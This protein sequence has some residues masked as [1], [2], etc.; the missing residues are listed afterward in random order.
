M[1]RVEAS[2]R[3]TGTADLFVAAGTDVR[4]AAVVAEMLVERTLIGHSAHGSGQ[5]EAI[6][7]RCPRRAQRQRHLRRSRR[8][9]CLYNL[10]R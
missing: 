4:K 2:R 5:I 8:T 9:R 7:T 10:A 1:M 6:L 3:R